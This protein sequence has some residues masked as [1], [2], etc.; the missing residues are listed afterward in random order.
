MPLIASVPPLFARVVVG[1]PASCGEV[2]LSIRV[3][4]L[5]GALPRD[6]HFLVSG[7]GLDRAGQA[8][9]L[10]LGEAFPSGAQDGLDSVERVAFPSTMPERLLLDASPHLVDRA[11]SELD[12]MERIEHRGRVIELLIDRGLVSRE[13]VESCDLDTVT[14]RRAAALQPARVGLPRPARHEVQQTRMRDA[15]LVASEVDHPRQLL[16]AALTRVDVMPDVFVD[17][18]RPHAGEAG[19]VACKAFEDGPD[20]APE[21]LPCRSHLAGEAGRSRVRGGAVR[22]PTRP[23]GE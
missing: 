21:R 19:L 15:V 6:E 9:A 11:C 17:T 5:L 13:R 23:R 14:E 1:D 20:G 18:E 7:V 16:R 12:D 2:L 3:A 22:S 10:L 4:E 8:S